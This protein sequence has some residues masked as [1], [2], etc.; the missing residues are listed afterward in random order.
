MEFSQDKLRVERAKL[1]KY[2]CFHMNLLMKT[3]TLIFYSTKVFK[4]I[5]FLVICSKI[6]P[7]KKLI[8]VCN[9]S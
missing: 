5:S 1:K 2:G 3:A 7:Y 4:L 6:Q 9:S 8:N